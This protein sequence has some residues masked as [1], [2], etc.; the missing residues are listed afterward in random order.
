MTTLQELKQQRDTP[1]KAIKLLEQ[2]ISVGDYVK[3]KDG[4]WM[5]SILA[6]DPIL[7]HR[8]E[9]APLS[10]LADK[11]YIVAHIGGSFP[12]DDEHIRPDRQ[13]NIIIVSS[14]GDVIFCQ[15]LNIRKI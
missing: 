10:P 4:S 14:D 7:K 8:Y 15:E 11:T 13:N 6:R 12:T 1:D 3:I 2:K 5:M 9:N